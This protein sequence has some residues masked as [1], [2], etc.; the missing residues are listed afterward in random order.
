MKLETALKNRGV[1]KT[2]TV[3]QHDALAQPYASTNSL[4]TFL[5]KKSSIIRPNLAIM[6]SPEPIFVSSA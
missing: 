3:P 5:V 2:F 6:R 1:L 4:S